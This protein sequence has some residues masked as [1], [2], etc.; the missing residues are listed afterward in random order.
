MVKD[1]PNLQLYVSLQD[2]SGNTYNGPNQPLVLTVVL[3]NGAQ[4]N[5][6][7]S[8]NVYPVPVAAPTGMVTQTGL[9]SGVPTGATLAEVDPFNLGGTQAVAGVANFIVPAGTTVNGPP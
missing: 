3:L 8:T 4:S 5:A 6:A 2:S 7:T 9:P 1:T